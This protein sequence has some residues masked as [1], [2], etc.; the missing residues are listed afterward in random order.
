MHKCIETIYFTLATVLKGGHLIIPKNF[1][2]KSAEVLRLKHNWRSV[3][4]LLDQLKPG[5]HDDPCKSAMAVKE[6][7]QY[8]Y[9]ED[10]TPLW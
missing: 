6:L 10:I 2:D 9:M 3:I 7:T 4:I 1:E 5:T 8:E